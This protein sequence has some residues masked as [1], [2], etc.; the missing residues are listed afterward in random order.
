MLWKLFKVRNSLVVVI[1]VVLLANV[2]RNGGCITDDIEIPNNNYDMIPLEEPS[3]ENFEVD[4]LD[5]NNGIIPLGESDTDIR[6]D[7][8][9]IEINTRPEEF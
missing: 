5:E 8:S 9:N 6:D 1:A 3:D 4:T 7:D 2:D